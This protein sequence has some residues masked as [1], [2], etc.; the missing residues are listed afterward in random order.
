MFPTLRQAMYHAMQDEIIGK[1]KG[2]EAA[3]RASET[4]LAIRRNISDA[5]CPGGPQKIRPKRNP[6]LI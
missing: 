2:R 1:L 5:S 6:K 3:S 4:R